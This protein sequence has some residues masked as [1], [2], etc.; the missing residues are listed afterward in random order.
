M[1]KSIRTEPHDHGAEGD[2]RIRT[3]EQAPGADAAYDAHGSADTLLA[4]VHRR[5]GGLGV[6]IITFGESHDVEVRWRRS[7]DGV[8]S[9]ERFASARSI[10]GA[11]LC[12]LDHEHQADIDD[13]L[14]RGAAS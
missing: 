9:D 8:L 1:S 10:A 11:L 2:E 6:D 7:Y 3:A 4:E 5:I 12:I 14:E 13:A